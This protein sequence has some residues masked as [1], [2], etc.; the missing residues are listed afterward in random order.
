MNKKIDSTLLP[1]IT[2]LPSKQ[3]RLSKLERLKNGQK[4]EFEAL[5]NKHIDNKEDKEVSFSKHAVKRLQERNLHLDSNE[6]LKL[7]EAMSKLQQKGSKESLVI[8]SNAAYI[9]DVNNSKVVTAMDK[10]N[11]NENVFTNIDSTVFMN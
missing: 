4:S 9:V 6:Y 11:M 7:K 8:T 1:Q 3:E 2:K 10:D 5:F